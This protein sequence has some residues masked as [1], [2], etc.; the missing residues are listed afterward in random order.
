MS[1]DVY[2]YTHEPTI[3]EKKQQ[4]STGRLDTPAFLKWAEQFQ[5]PAMDYITRAKWPDTLL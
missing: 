1:D 3:E 4:L 2:E 5:K